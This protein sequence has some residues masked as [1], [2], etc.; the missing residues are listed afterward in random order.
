MKKEIVE[1]LAELGADVS[2]L[3]GKSLAKDLQLLQ[4]GNFLFEED[5][6][7]VGCELIDNYLED[8]KELFEEQP[9]EFYLQITDYFWNYREGKAPN[10][11]YLGQTYYKGNLLSPF[12]QSSDDFEEWNDWFVNEADLSEIKEVVGETCD[13]LSFVNIFGSHGFPDDYFVCLQDPNPENPS[14]FGTDHEVFFIEVENYGTLSEFLGTMLT[15]EQLRVQIKEY[16][17][18]ELNA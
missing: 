1:R 5:Y 14:V 16:I 7:D 11:I 10:E 17:E 13:E 3:E 4:F 18:E 12:D 15:K 6:L 9:E 8:H 2:R